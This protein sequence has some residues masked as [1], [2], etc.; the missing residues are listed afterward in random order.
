MIDFTGVRSR[1]LQRA[2]FA[3]LAAYFAVATFPPA[4]QKLNTDFPNYY[5]TARMAREHVDTARAYE[6]IWIEREKDH[7]GI[8]QRIVGLVPITPFSTLLV[9]PIASF[10][11]L[12]AKHI[13]IVF[14]ATLLIA[15]LLMLPRVSGLTLPQ[16]GILIA[17]SYPLRFNFLLGQY[18]LLL[19]AILTAACWAAQRKRSVIAGCLV[20]MAIAL[21]IFPII[22]LVHFLRRRD[23]RAALA[24]GTTILAALCLS[25]AVLGLPMHR[26][27]VLQVLPSTL[28][29]EGL[30]SFALGSSSLS[31]VLHRLFIYEP[32]WNPHP[33]IQAAWLF[34]VLHPVLQ[35]LILLPA[36]LL[37]SR[38]D[39]SPDR[40]ALEWSA[41]IVVSLCL[42]TSPG[43]Y[44]FTLAIFPAAALC[45]HLLRTRAY[46]LLSLTIIL[47]LAI[48]RANWHIQ[49]REGWGTLLCVP[50]LCAL[51]LLSILIFV[52]L[53]RNRSR[54]SRAEQIVWLIV[55][56]TS[57]LL[58]I[59]S[60]IRHQRHLFDDYAYRLPMP[61]SVLMA[62]HPAAYGEDTAAFVGLSIDGYRAM[63]LP[64]SRGG[65]IEQLADRNADQLSIASLQGQALTEDVLLT[66]TLHSSNDRWP[67]I[68]NAES[69]VISPDATTVAYL[70]Q[71]DGRKQLFIRSLGTADMAEH[72]LTSAPLN[73][74]EASFLKANDLV[75][76]ATFPGSKPMLYRLSRTG[77]LTPL[78][79]EEVR[80]PAVSPDGR[81]LAFSK[82]MED[83]WNLYLLDLQSGAVRRI[84]DVPCNQIEPAWEPDSK[85]LLYATDC[86]R[87]LWFTA[88]ARRQILP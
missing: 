62:A 11:A 55:L 22:L 45:G 65:S 86:G 85:I 60:G 79:V 28:R 64:S 7:R 50:R 67:S 83:N 32:Q 30:P 24:C 31:T 20:G 71:I 12:A 33:A 52:V 16:A 25:I 82:F 46:V 68:S 74:Y 78:V 27:Y 36:V 61:S 42:S 63:T 9:W 39:V 77:V 49:P 6:W 15:L 80:Y 72:Q 76:S 40:T 56:G 75:V 14:N 88:I 58:S 8:D 17:L 84:A 2:L 13:W 57:T 19:L 18:Y 47:Y 3:L 59:A 35:L 41:L 54:V 81:W 87:S 44:L 66:S 26:T 23:W 21:K 37:I 53:A 34:A 4:W 70:R 69:P 29:G 43:S 48:N 10:N 5:L 38:E 51:I 1:W 73:V